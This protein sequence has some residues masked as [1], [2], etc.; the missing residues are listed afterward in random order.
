MP[1][2]A[3]GPALRPAHHVFD[4][5]V[6]KVEVKRLGDVSPRELQHDNPELRTLDE[7]V[8]FLGQLYNREVSDEDT[9]TVIHFSE[10]RPSPQ[11]GATPRRTPP[12]PRRRTTVRPRALPARRPRRPRRPR[13]RR[14]RRLGDARVALRLTA[15]RAAE[16][17]GVAE[18]VA[19]A[20]A[21]DLHERG[22]ALAAAGA[23]RDHGLSA[24]GAALREIDRDAGQEPPPPAAAGAERGAVPELVLACQHAPQHTV[25][26]LARGRARDPECV[27][28]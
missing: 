20:G 8:F 19:A 26:V 14:D 4:A 21:R 7:F 6:D 1:Q 3:H 17:L 24:V 27:I 23:G 16:E 15:D 11:I 18:L 22:D 13:P 5:V 9:V 10:I 2:G 25:G 12:P 28:A